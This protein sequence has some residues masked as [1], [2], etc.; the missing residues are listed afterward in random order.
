V[1]RQ[2][3]IAALVATAALVFAG[4]ASASTADSSPPAPLRVAASPRHSAAG[5]SATATHA[6]RSRHGRRHHRHLNT[7]KAQLRARDTWT[8]TGASSPQPVRRS[9][10]PRH[11]A[12][13]PASHDR[14]QA[15]NRNWSQSAAA[16]ATLVGMSPDASRLDAGRG[17]RIASRIELLSLGRGPPRASPL[18]PSSPSCLGAFAFP[19]HPPIPTQHHLRTSLVVPMTRDRLESRP[20]ADRLEGAVACFGMPSSR[21]PS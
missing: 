20:H 13:R 10:P 18:E 2:T 5:A 7:E 8:A 9:F 19:A 14:P 1:Q 17:D 3:L 6:G 12:L 21:R 16:L 15:R 11:A 4:A